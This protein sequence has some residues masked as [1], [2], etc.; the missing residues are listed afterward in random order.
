MRKRVIS[1]LMA[2][3]MALTLLPVTAMAEENHSHSLHYSQ[4]NPIY[5][6]VIHEGDLLGSQPHTHSAVAVQR[7]DYLFT[8]EE[9]AADI[10]QHLVNRETQFTVHFVT[11][12]APTDDDVAICFVAALIETE[13]A[14]EGDYLIYQWGGYDAAGDVN[15]NGG[16]YYTDLT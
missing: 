15:Q 12:E 10:R 3:L 16:Y 4:V 7:A 8:T 2:M 1:F 6:D 14:Y 13:N 9:V 5:A 11:E